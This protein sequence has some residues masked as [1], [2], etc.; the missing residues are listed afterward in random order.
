MAENTSSDV[1]I[2]GGCGHAGLPLGIALALAGLKTVLYDVDQCAVDT[3]NDASMPFF[4]HG[5]DEALSQALSSNMLSATADPSSIQGATN[6]IVVIGTPVNQYLN[7]DLTAVQDA[8]EDV[9]PYMSDGQLVV[10]RSTVFPGITRTVEKMMATAGLDID[11]AF[12]PERTAEG[13]ALRELSEL[14]QIVAGCTEPATARAAAMFSNLSPK[15]IYLEPEEAEVAKLITNSWRYIKF[16]TANQF[17]MLANDY[18]LDY[19]RIRSAVVDD[20]PRA[21]DLPRAGFSAGP[22][23]LKDTMQLAAYNNNDF[24]FGQA[25]MNINEGLPL[26]V[27]SKLADRYDLENMT[28]GILGMAFKA[29]TDDVRW[30]LSYKLRRIL[31]FRSKEVLCTDPFVDDEQLVSLDTVLERSDLLI[32]GAPHSVY[33]TLD[34]KQPVADVWGIFERGV[35]V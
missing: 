28:V 9:V 24:L 27:V 22:C 34:P 1:A 26:Y 4:E 35:R 25:A 32:V 31:Q 16:A 29:D 14:P 17:Y 18:G 8:I 21:A 6:V 15:I 13:Y 11:V 12:C 2:I 5:A 3:I 10:L 30:S 19:E 33:R 7:P 20:Y 23:L